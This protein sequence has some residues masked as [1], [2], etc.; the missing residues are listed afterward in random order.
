MA[1]VNRIVIA[2]D[3]RL[4][5]ES[6]RNVLQRIA[7]LDVVAT[8]AAADAGV[9]ARQMC[10][11]VVLLDLAAPR[12]FDVLHALATPS[13]PAVVV[14]ALDDNGSE[15][16][17]CIEAGARGYVTREGSVDDLVATVRSVARGEMLCSPRFA[18]V[19]VQRLAALA[20]ARVT[21]ES[22]P[23]TSREREIVAL[24]DRG[25]ANK[26]IARTL[27]IEVATVKN[28]IHN[29]LEKL[30]VRRRAEAAARLRRMPAPDASRGGA[31]REA[32]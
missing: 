22:T 30:H 18:A 17:S 25:L 13:G 16:L 2:S 21:D 5:R 10:A 4:Y 11:D 23:L 24:L 1:D 29:I 27:G 6:L 14:L 32:R 8:V 20:S 19:M 28:H 31:P 26:E 3:V 15:V 7:D 9:V 12:R